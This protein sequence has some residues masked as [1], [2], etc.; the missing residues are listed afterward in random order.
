MAISAQDVK[1]LRDR[2]G[3]GMADCKKAL[4][5]AGGDM[6]GAI[7]ILR[8]KGAATAAKRADKSANEGVIGS[9]I[10]FDNKTAVIVELNCETDFVANT[11]AFRALAKDLA[12]HIASAAPL[13]V[14]PDQIDPAVV[15][16][17]RFWKKLG[18]P[19]PSGYRSMS[20]GR[21][22]IVRRR[23]SSTRR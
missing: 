17:T 19:A 3:A 16:R 10:H 22:R 4:E 2:T 7:E 21:L 18:P 12:L 11:D 1:L 14:S 13:A 23:G 5:E 9:Y 8:K 6:D 20:V 15:E